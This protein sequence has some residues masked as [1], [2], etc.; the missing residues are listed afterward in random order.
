[1][2][3]KIIYPILNVA[4]SLLPMQDEIILES[5]PD[6]TCNTFELYR[7][8]IK[9]GLNKKYKLT[10]LVSDPER[11]K[12][13][14]N[15]YNVSFIYNLP[16]GL[17]DKAKLYIRTNRAKVAIAC[18][19]RIQRY[20]TSKKQL[21]IYLDHGSQMKNMLIN[22][23]RWDVY[24]DYTISQSQFFAPYIMEQYNVE[25]DQVIVTG[26]PRNDQLYKK[27]DS[28]SRIISDIENYKK[29]IIWVPTLRQ[30]RN[31]ARIDCKS[32][33]PFG[34]PLLYSQDM[35]EQLNELLEETETLLIIKP[36]P[37]QFLGAIK[38]FSSNNIRFIYND[39]LLEHE[40]QTN[41]LL[42][43]TDAMITD[44]SSIYYD[45]LLLDRPIAITLDDFKEY[46]DQKGFVF[47]NP[48]DVL[49]GY[50]L[51]DVKDLHSFIHDVACGIDRSLLER[52]EVK[53][54]I[55]DYQ[56]DNSSKRVYDFIVK[57]LES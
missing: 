1:M 19:K 15:D 54:F 39:D 55:D 45:Y 34:L 51:Y 44:Y 24:C 20:R 29:V 47:R 36:H 42:S 28:I 7:Y 49:K 50:Y 21:N 25:R 11:C 26:L 22:G 9:Q 33:F 56:D 37:A 41:E 10:W 17:V 2:Q 13:L 14:Y 57:K 35:I 46:N 18:N 30:H 12:R 23:I 40:I 52:T 32:N 5:H 4:C 27:Y 31:V 38:D 53:R 16:K 48:F 8:M 3:V 43:Q 6:L